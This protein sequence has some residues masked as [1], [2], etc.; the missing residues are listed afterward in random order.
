MFD[1]KN[2]SVYLIDKIEFIVTCFYLIFN[3]LLSFVTKGTI[4][5]KTVHNTVYKFHIKKSEGYHHRSNIYVLLG[6]NFVPLVRKSRNFVRL[7]SFLYV[8]LSC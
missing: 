5:K 4:L 8:W 3:Q 1:E 7:K 6:I 2:V